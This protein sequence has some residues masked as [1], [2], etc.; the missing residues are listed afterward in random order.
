MKALLSIVGVLLCTGLQAQPVYRCGADGRTYSQAPCPEG[1]TVDV[2]DERSTE[3]RA[4]AKAVAR[5]DQSLGNAMERERLNRDA[6]APAR[7]GKIDGQLMAHAQPV[8]ATP[9]AKSSKKKRQKTQSINDDFKAISPAPA[10]K[11]KRSA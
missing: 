9:K 4:A 3:Q 6:S 10:K 8:A 1:R 5:N 2:S 7:P 11:A